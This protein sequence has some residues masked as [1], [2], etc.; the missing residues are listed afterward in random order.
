MSL[1]CLLRKPFLWT[2]CAHFLLSS[3]QSLLGHLGCGH[4]MTVASWRLVAPWDSRA[5][6]GS[7]SHPTAQPGT[8]QSGASGKPQPQALGTSGG[9]ANLPLIPDA[10]LSLPLC[11]HHVAHPGGQIHPQHN[12]GSGTEKFA[13][14]NFMA[15]S[16]CLGKTASD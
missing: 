12:Q 1:L 13:Q 15:S 14:L 8:G 4:S 11:F 16:M 9:S 7:T 5:G 10:L 6:P 2:K 3:P